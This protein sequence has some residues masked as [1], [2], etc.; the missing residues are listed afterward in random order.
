MLNRE[1]RKKRTITVMARDD[2]NPRM[3]AYFDINIHL[4]DVNDKPTE[5]V[6][7]PSNIP[8]GVQPGV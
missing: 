2:G 7:E 4:S 3:K 5:V 1:K 8:E 6:L